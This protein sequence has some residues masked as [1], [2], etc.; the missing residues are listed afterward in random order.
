MLEI[1]K[2]KLNLLGVD[3]KLKITRHL[4]NSNKKTLSILLRGSHENK[5][6]RF[7][8]FNNGDGMRFIECGDTVRRSVSS[9]RDAKY[10]IIKYL[11][12]S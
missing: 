8:Y 1:Q 4:N 3:Y 10:M 12:K 7:Y 9:I 5:S 2:N 6:S 11:T